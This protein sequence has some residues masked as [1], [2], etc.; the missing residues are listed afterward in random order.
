[1]TVHPIQNLGD[2]GTNCYI[3]ET[4]A[5]TA[6]LIDAPYSAEPIIGELERRGLALGMILLTHGHCDHIEALGGLTEKYGCEVYISPADAPMLKSP[7]ASLAE[8]FGVPFTPFEGAKLLAD[9]QKITLDGVTLR[10]LFTPGHSAGSVSYL[11]EKTVFTGDTLFCGSVGRTDL[12]GSYGEMM[13]SIKKLCAACPFCDIYP[14]H[15]PASDIDSELRFNPY[16]AGLE[17]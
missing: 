4:P 2:F 16:L 17:I 15:G 1:M 6:M 3:V 11:S 14:G 9:G 7:S 12:G 5:K 10:V 13:R 8:Y